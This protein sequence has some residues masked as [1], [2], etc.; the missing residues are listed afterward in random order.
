MSQPH[1]SQTVSG[2]TPTRGKSEGPPPAAKAQTEFAPAE[3]APALERQIVD[4]VPTPGVKY[5][6]VIEH[7]WKAYEAA[8]A[9]GVQVDEKANRLIAFLGIAVSGVTALLAAGDGSLNLWVVIAALPSLLAALAAVSLAAFGQ[10]P[11]VQAAPPTVRKAWEAAEYHTQEQA[12]K[13]H[14][15]RFLHQA[16]QNRRTRTAAKARRVRTATLAAVIALWLLLLP[17][18]ALLGTQW[19]SSSV[20]T[21]VPPKHPRPV[22]GGR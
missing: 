22:A 5:D 18:V 1:V 8:K 2:L 13:G 4:Y 6:W 9:D 3:A 10:T 16:E 20:L 7:G 15:A 11:Q 21:V 19:H 17:V 14:F 12:A